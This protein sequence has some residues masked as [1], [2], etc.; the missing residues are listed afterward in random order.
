MSD[1]TAP[2]TV[3][4]P[5]FRI[6]KPQPPV[7]EK[8]VKAP[9]PVKVNNVVRY[10]DTAGTLLQTMKKQRGK[11]PFCAVKQENG[12]FEV[13]NCTTSVVVED[14]KEVTLIEKP[15]TVKEVFYINSDGTKELKGKGPSRK[16]YLKSEEDGNW[17]EIQAA[18]TNVE[19][20]IGS[21]RIVESEEPTDR[22]VSL[23]ERIKAARAQTQTQT[24]EV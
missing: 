23:S 13:H 6:V 15:K 1:S 21:E 5:A 22:A 8:V 2:A 3:S 18:S 20:A 24:T 17:Y 14:G 10:Y 11:M 19:G 9:K 16:N 12:D 7:K 4:A